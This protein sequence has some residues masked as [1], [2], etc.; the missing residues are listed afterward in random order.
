VKPW[1]DA[2]ALKGRVE[3]LKSPPVLHFA[4]HGFFLPSEEKKDPG[5]EELLR[6]SGLALTGAN[7]RAADDAPSSEAGNGILTALDVM[8]LS[9]AGT[10]LVVLSAC[11]TGLGEV[12]VGEGV[13]GLR[14]AFLVAGARTLVVSLWRVPDKETRDLMC[15]MYEQLQKGAGVAEVRDPARGR[16]SIDQSVPRVA[17]Q[18]ERRPGNLAGALRET[19]FA[20]PAHG[21]AERIPGEDSFV[22]RHREGRRRP[23]VHGPDGADAGNRPPVDERRRQARGRQLQILLHRLRLRLVRREPGLAGVQEHERP[24]FH[25]PADLLGE[26]HLLLV[27]Q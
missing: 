27:Q 18:D 20:V 6:R 21:L 19:F 11:E 1:L 15:G 5:P 12:R 26:E 17:M 10:E 16:S 7:V 4:T 14:R 25:Q 8:S 24:A 9:L 23:V 13:F 22:E 2:E 3:A